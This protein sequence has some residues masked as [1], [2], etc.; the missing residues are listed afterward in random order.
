MWLLSSLDRV[1][2]ERAVGSVGC[3]TEQPHEEFGG[4]DTPPLSGHNFGFSGFAF[5]VFSE[6][7]PERILFTHP[8]T[9]PWGDSVPF[10]RSE[11]QEPIPGTASFRGAANALCPGAVFPAD[12][13]GSLQHSI[14]SE[15]QVARSEGAVL[16]VTTEQDNTVPWPT[17]WEFPRC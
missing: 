15:V 10:P 9:T 11:R 17:R 5:R 7:G 4:A 12:P 1:V 6:F 16:K 2:G 3:M 8:I 14:C 13:F